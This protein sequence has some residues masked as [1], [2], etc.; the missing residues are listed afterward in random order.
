MM[1]KK[2][3]KTLKIGKKPS[4]K[5][6]AIEQLIHSAPNEF[7][8]RKWKD[9]LSALEN[10]DAKERNKDLGPRSANLSNHS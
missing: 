5:Y 2:E 8:R 9:A 7:L 1:K 6:E 10:R 3:Q 4:S